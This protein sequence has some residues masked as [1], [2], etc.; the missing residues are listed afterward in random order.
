MD[1]PVAEASDSA[2]PGQ[3]GSH[4]GGGIGGRYTEP[5]HNAVPLLFFQAP[6]LFP[7]CR[8]LSVSADRPETRKWERC[9]RCVTKDVS[10][11]VP[12]VCF[13]T[14]MLI[15]FSPAGS[16]KVSRNCTPVYWR[17]GRRCCMR[18]TMGMNILSSW[19]PGFR[20]VN[21]VIVIS[22]SVSAESNWEA[23]VGSG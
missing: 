7:G 5:L 15:C 20:S 13:R 16:G 14:G 17:Y 9:L 8:L 18:A 22:S 11:V 23:G 1:E 2:G 19:M 21:W 4:G 12:S 6:S 10:S 3:W